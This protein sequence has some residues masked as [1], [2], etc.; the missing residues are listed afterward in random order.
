MV[1]RS[2]VSAS[3]QQL[4]NAVEAEDATWF[5]IVHADGQARIGEVVTTAAQPWMVCSRRTLR[6]T[7]GPAWAGG[8]QIPQ[9]T[10]RLVGTHRMTAAAACTTADDDVTGIVWVRKPARPEGCRNVRG[11]LSALSKA[12]PAVRPARRGLYLVERGKA[13]LASLGA[14][15]AWLQHAREELLE[16]LAAVGR[17]A[18]RCHLAGAHVELVPLG[19]DDSPAAYVLVR[20]ETRPMERGPMMDLT[21]LQLDV[22]QLA[23]NGARVGE[24]AEHLGRSQETIRTHLHNTYRVLGIGTRA[25]LATLHAANSW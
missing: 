17:R 6:G 22:V 20:H 25:E 9:R 10:L 19:Q 18:S 21:A 1:A 2:E 8:L 24:M 3:L 14:D 11:P 12:V 23:V 4:A 5:Q 16:A 15:I 7:L 13:P